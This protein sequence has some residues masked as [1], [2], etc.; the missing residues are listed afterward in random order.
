VRKILDSTLPTL[1]A[2]PSLSSG[3][4]MKLVTAIRDV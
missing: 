2:G 3:S 1:S 4:A